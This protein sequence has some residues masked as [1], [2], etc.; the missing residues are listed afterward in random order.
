M[1]IHLFGEEGDYAIWIDT[2]VQPRDGLCIGVG[3]TLAAAK[4][5]AA[6][7]LRAALDAVDALADGDAL[8]E[9]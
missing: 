8:P 1:K 2:D 3:E 7:E 5:D 9:D 6:S 4:A